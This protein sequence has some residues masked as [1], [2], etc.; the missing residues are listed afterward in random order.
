VTYEFKDGHDGDK[1]HEDPLQ[2]HVRPPNGRQEDGAGGERSGEYRH[3]RGDDAHGA[4]E[5][6]R[7]VEVPLLP[8][9]SEA[10]QT[11]GSR[12]PR[13][14]RYAVVRGRGLDVD[15]FGRALDGPEAVPSSHG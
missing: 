9:G 11:A 3:H 15:D 5:L 1:V 8:P 12:P 6:E 10:V 14:H 13:C 7:R 2:E 4:G